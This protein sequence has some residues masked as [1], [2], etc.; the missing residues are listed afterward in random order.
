GPRP[1]ESGWD[2]AARAAARTRATALTWVLWIGTAA[3]AL[4]LFLLSAERTAGWFAAL[5]LAEILAHAV[6][7]SGVV[8]LIR[9]VTLPDAPQPWHVLATK[10]LCFLWVV[11]LLRE[12]AIFGVFGALALVAGPVPA[13]IW[14]GAVVVGFV[15]LLWLVCVLRGVAV[16]YFI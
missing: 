7:V 9:R 4:T 6:V 5:L 16:F 1:P 2:A 13:E 11:C 8:F 10:V 3:G 14:I 12:V 15:G